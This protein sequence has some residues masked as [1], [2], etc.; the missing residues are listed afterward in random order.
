[1]ADRLGRGVAV[2]RATIVGAYRDDVAGEAARMSYYFFL[3]L[4]PFVLVIFAVTGLFGGDAAFEWI[5]RALRASVPD[6]AWQFV[7]DLIREVTS[8]RRPGVLSLGIVLTLWAASSGVAAL[9]SGLNTMYDVEDERPWWRRR[10]VA[11]LVLVTSVL[12]IVLAAAAFVP[13]MVWVERAGLTDVWQVA[14]W[15]VA[16]ALLTGTIWLGYQYLPAREQHHARAST[17]IGAGAAMAVWLVAT[18]AFRFYVANIGRFGRA[19][20]ALGAVIVLLIWIYLTA[21]AVLVGGELA[22]EIER[23]GRAG[24]A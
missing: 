12:L 5:T 9:M 19:Y 7:R 14:R 17:L 11:F 20:G 18:W 4:F 2:I 21:F 13:G 8:H 23:H 3:S 22:A 10:L 6:F 16:F 1:M 24:G 15:P